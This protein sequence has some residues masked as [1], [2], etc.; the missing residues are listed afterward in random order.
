MNVVY[1]AEQRSLRQSEERNYRRLYVASFPLFL[2]VAMAARLVPGH[3]RLVRAPGGVRKSI[4]VEAREA[5][6]ATIGFAFM[7]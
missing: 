3:V 5:A 4:L 7:H 6:H 1:P 2:I